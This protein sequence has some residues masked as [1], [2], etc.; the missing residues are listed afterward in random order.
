MVLCAQETRHFSPQGLKSGCCWGKL[1]VA[2]SLSLSDAETSGA[3]GPS[4]NKDDTVTY[5]VLQ[6]RHVVRGQSYAMEG[7]GAGAGGLDWQPLLGHT[8]QTVKLGRV[9]VSSPFPIA[10]TEY[11][12]RFTK[13]RDLF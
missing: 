3:Q 11:P 8:W 2:F 12:W 6:K 1:T 5:S 7:G 10:I 9:A 13:E 4:P